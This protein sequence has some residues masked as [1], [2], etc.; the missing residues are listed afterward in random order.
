M[1]QSLR[2]FGPALYHFGSNGTTANVL[3][4]GANTFKIVSNCGLVLPFSILA[5]T[6][7]FTPLNS[8]SFF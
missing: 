2:F 1:S 8:S 7:C 5:M 6:G 4:K 3:P